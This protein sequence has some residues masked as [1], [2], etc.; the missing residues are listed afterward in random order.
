MVR[1]HEFY[2]VFFIK[3][4]CD[5][6]DEERCSL[7]YWSSTIDDMHTILLCEKI[8]SF[9]DFCLEFFETLDDI[10]T[11]A[12]I[13]T[14]FIVLERIATDS[15]LSRDIYRNTEVESE[16]RNRKVRI[17][18]WLQ[19]LHLQSSRIS[20]SKSSIH[21][22]I[23]EHYHTCSECSAHLSEVALYKVRS[24]YSIEY[25]CWHMEV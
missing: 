15:T 18:K 20:T 22:P 14:S 19:V 10:V 17:V 8:V 12:D 3:V 21:I 23:T 9:D 1:S 5:F 16:V 6:F 13:H 24:I 4:S 11:V 7:I 2:I 25:C